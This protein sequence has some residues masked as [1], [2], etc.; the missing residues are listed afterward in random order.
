MIKQKTYSVPSIITGS[1]CR[2]W[3]R[4][5]IFENMKMEITAHLTIFN[6][7]TGTS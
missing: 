1:V 3:S 7:Y 2:R 4:L 6:L 5:S